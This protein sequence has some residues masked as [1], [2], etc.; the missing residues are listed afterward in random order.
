VMPVPTAAA[1][2]ALVAQPLPSVPTASAPPVIPMARAG[3]SAKK[4]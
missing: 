1:P 3:A 2:A 4:P